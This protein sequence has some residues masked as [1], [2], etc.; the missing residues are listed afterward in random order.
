MDGKYQI[1]QILMGD[2]GT[3]HV[4]PVGLWEKQTFGLF[5]NDDLYWQEAQLAYSYQGLPESVCAKPCQPGEFLI[6]QDVKCCWQCEKCRNNEIVTADGLSCRECP[7]LTW[8]NQEDFLSCVVITPSFM[9][10]S[11]PLPMIC[12]ILSI[13]G[14]L[15]SSTIL[16]LMQKYK[17]EKLIKATS[18]GLSMISLI[19]VILSCITSILLIIRPSEVICYTARFCFNLSFAFAYAPLLAKVTRIYRIFSA[20]K[21]GVMTVR[22]ISNKGQIVLTMAL[23]SIQVSKPGP[24]TGPKVSP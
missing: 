7:T 18:K 9:E 15:L 3:V 2:S 11:D 1:N 5:L 21:R 4:N 19:G 13:L 17:N 16:T 12:V 14:L 10:M 20:G 6:R 23:I 22:F 24:G 8:P